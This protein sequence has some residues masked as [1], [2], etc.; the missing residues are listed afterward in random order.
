MFDLVTLLRLSQRRMPVVIAIIAVLMM[1]IAPE[2]SKTLE[3]RRI[4]AKGEIAEKTMS[5]MFGIAMSGMHSNDMKVHAI[6]AR[7]KESSGKS[8]HKKN[9]HASR[10]SL[11]ADEGGMMDNFACGYCQLLVHFPLMIWIFV[12][13]IW[14]ILLAYRAPPIRSIPTYPTSLFS[15]ISQPRA[16]PTCLFFN[17]MASQL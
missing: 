5:N 8:N 11:M 9:Q 2:V 7:S 15:G 6:S 17:L 3:H 14:L 4:P 12:P 16:P 1:F 13:L 10:D